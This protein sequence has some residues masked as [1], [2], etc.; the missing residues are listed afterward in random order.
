MRTQKEVNPIEGRKR[1]RETWIGKEKRK[2]V[3][4]KGGDRRS[5]EIRNIRERKE[6]E[7]TKTGEVENNLRVKT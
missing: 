5:G 6:T 2:R 7:K 1:E 4:L 3:G